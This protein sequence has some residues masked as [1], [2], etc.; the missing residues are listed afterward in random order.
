M[1]KITLPTIAE[2]AKAKP[3]SY[4]PLNKEFIYYDKVARGEQ[5]IY[6]VVKLDP[7]TRVKLSIKR[8]ECSEENMLVS[9]LNGETYS[10]NKIVM[11]I[12]QGTAIGMNFLSLDLNYLEY[13]LSTFPEKVFEK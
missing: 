10:K 3:L 6:P 8:Y 1:E 9:T 2:E 5:K 13:F 4:N 7:Q 11:E 12:T